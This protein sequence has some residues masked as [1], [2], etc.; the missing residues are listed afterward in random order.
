MSPFYL[1][2]RLTIV[3]LAVSSKIMCSPIER[4]YV[5]VKTPCKSIV[6]AINRLYSS[7]PDHMPL[8]ARCKQYAVLLSLSKM[9][10]FTNQ[11]ALLRTLELEED[12]LDLLYKQI[13]TADLASHHIAIIDI[14][15]KSQLEPALI[16][17]FE[18]LRRIDTPQVKSYLNHPELVMTIDLYKLALG[19]PP[20]SID[21]D[22]VD[23]GA[24]DPAF[25]ITL[26]NL[27]ESHFKIARRRGSSHDAFK[28]FSSKIL[29]GEIV[30]QIRK[31]EMRRVRQQRYR[32][33]HLTRVRENDR[34]RRKRERDNNQLLRDR[35]EGAP[36]RSQQ[37][38]G[39]TVT[40]LIER[41]ERGRHLNRER[42]R[43][44]R[45][46]RK[47]RRR[48][49]QRSECL[50]QELDY[51]C[52]PTAGSMPRRTTVELPLSTSTAMLMPP[53]DEPVTFKPPRP[54]VNPLTSFPRLSDIPF[55]IRV[56]RPDPFILSPQA[57]DINK[58]DSRQIC[59][60]HYYT[61][62]REDK[63]WALTL[64]RFDSINQED[65]LS[66]L[67]IFENQFNDTDSVIQ[68]FSD[69]PQTLHEYNRSHSPNGN[70]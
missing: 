20:K 36:E 49:Q 44:F 16:D 59:Q 3:I 17:L 5:D 68:A 43:R 1:W 60:A 18:C 55:D 62:D 24:F 37:I 25:R 67:N 64:G 57:F 63:D 10:G 34:A 21:L 30:N 48:L 6:D 70:Q 51:L 38:E 23:L 28:Q 27:F 54:L 12:T 58:T 2:R 56:A 29:A 50:G 8:E 69:D 40:Q 35:V 32:E 14:Y 41:F 61:G 7:I 53:G 4:I 13:S 66:D 42:Q 52:I 11:L 31:I 19:P 15:R 33:K 46:R 47:Q 65:C 9:R 45:Q 39:T 22:S 26:A